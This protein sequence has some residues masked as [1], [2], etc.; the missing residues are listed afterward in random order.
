MDSNPLHGCLGGLYRPTP[1]GYNGNSTGRGPSRQCLWPPISPP[2]AGARRL[3]GPAD[4]SG[5]ELSGRVRRGR[6]LPAAD[7]CSRA[8]D[9]AGLVRGVW[10][11]SRRLVGDHCSHTV[12][13]LVNGTLALGEGATACWRPASRSSGWSSLRRL[14]GSLCLVESVAC[15]P[16]RHA[17]VGTGL[18]RSVVA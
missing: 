6:V 15:G 17:V 10:L 14:P 12:S 16:Y 8:S 9:D 1:Q 11:Q 18:R 4:W 3:V 7:Y 5:T 13:H 2:T